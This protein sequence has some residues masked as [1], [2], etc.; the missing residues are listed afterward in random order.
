[1]S[2]QQDFP[3]LTV[4]LGRGS[5]AHDRGTSYKVESI[6]VAGEACEAKAV[7]QK[8][9]QIRKGWG[10][11]GENDDD[12]VKSVALAF[13]LS[14]AKQ[15]EKKW[16]RSE[17]PQFSRFPAGMDYHQ[18]KAT[19]MDLEDGTRAVVVTGFRRG[20]TGNHGTNYHYEVKA[21]NAQTGE[22]LPVELEQQSSRERG[23]V[24]LTENEENDKKSTGSKLPMRR[25]FVS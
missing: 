24:K 9:V 21:F 4:N 19:F 10:Q 13:V 5:F 1:M 16:I 23:P 14:F 8:I 7:L 22:T 3:E 17:S 18:P 25:R 20:Y 11:S 6:T 15:I 2:F 12:T